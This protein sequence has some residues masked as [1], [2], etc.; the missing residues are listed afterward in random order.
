MMAVAVKTDDSQ[1]VEVARNADYAIGDILYSSWGWEQTNVSFYQ[2]IALKGKAS[3]VVKEVSATYRYTHSM[4]GYKKPIVD[5]FI[6]DELVA[7]INKHGTPKVQREF[8]H[9]LKFEL[10]DKGEK[11]YAEEYFSTYA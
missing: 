11:V 6:T 8:L 7:R 3:L 10:N 5:Q 2:V 9:K 1:A 4:A